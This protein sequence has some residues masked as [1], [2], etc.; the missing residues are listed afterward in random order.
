[1]AIRSGGDRFSYTLVPST[2]GTIG[3]VWQETQKGPKVHKVLLPRDQAPTELAIKTMF[4]GAYP[5]SCPDITAL[6]QQISRFLQGEDVAFRLD[7]LAL[8]TRQPFQ[9]RVLLAEH[10]IPRGWVSTYGR[11]ATSLGVPR[12]ARA[13]GNA[14]ARNPFPILIPCHRAIQSGGGLGGFQGG[15]RIKRA[16]L[17]L[18]GVEFL[19]TGRVVTDRVYY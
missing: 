5:L 13:V 15:V 3:L 16:L 2:F 10:Q 8:E 7:M 6:G 14:L 12:A 4:V 11:I 17:E 19:P 1:M 9:R 18:E